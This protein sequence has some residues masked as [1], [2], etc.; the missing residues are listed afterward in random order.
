MLTLCANKVVF[1]Y[2]HMYGVR[3][4]LQQLESLRGLIVSFKL[5]IVLIPF[6]VRGSPMKC[7]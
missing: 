3:V 6:L 5:V 7:P 4:H 2:N 1:F